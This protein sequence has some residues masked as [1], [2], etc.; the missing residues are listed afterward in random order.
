MRVLN[1][2]FL[3]LLLVALLAPTPAARPGK[4]QHLC[5]FPSKAKGQRVQKSMLQLLD[6][7]NK[8]GAV[9]CSITIPVPLLQRKG[10][11]RILASLI[12][13]PRKHTESRHF[14]FFKR[15]YH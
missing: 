10:K 4:Q 13:T 8:L 11:S 2:L 14:H 3:I 9:V 1:L 5:A 6:G 12:L 7:A 15:T